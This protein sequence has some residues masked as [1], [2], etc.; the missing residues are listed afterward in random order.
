MKPHEI[1]EQITAYLLGEL[2]D[3]AAEAVRQQLGTD[4]RCRAFAQDLEA[5][6]S[7]VR[8]ALAAES[9]APTALDPERKAALVAA[10][11]Q[12]GPES[13]PA[14][15]KTLIVFPR[16]A[17]WFAQAAAVAA[18]VVVL[19][20]VLSVRFTGRSSESA[21][22]LRKS[23]EDMVVASAEQ[24]A[25]MESFDD[26]AQP[27]D[28]ADMV[29]SFA[30]GS[31]DRSESESLIHAS[32]FRTRQ[33]TA[34]QKEMLADA[35][36]V[37]GGAGRQ[38]DEPIDVAAPLPR[39][40]PVTEPTITTRLAEPMAT[41]GE[42]AQ[43]GA[44]EAAMASTIGDV[45]VLAAR[46]GDREDA[47]GSVLFADTDGD[48]LDVSMGQAASEFRP[49]S[50]R[51]ARREG[52]A[53]VTSENAVGYVLRSPQPTKGA[54][55]RAPEGD[56]SDDAPEGLLGREIVGWHEAPPEE[57]ELAKSF[58]AF[59]APDSVPASKPGVAGDA[60]GENEDLTAGDEGVVVLNGGAAFTVKKDSLTDIAE[61]DGISPE[62]VDVNGKVAGDLERRMESVSEAIHEESREV[63]FAWALIDDDGLGDGAEDLPALDAETPDEPR[64]QPNARIATKPKGPA[65][66]AGSVAGDE[67]GTVVVLGD[68]PLV[69]KL[70]AKGEVANEESGE[71]AAGAST[72]VLGAKVKGTTVAAEP[73]IGKYVFAPSPDSAKEGARTSV[74]AGGVERY[75][76]RY[77]GTLGRVDERQLAEAGGISMFASRPSHP[78][79]DTAVEPVSTFG[80]DVD[81][82]SYTLA[83]LHILRGF[84][85][86]PEAIRV[87]EVVNAF[88]YDYE[89]PVKQTFAVRATYAPA[90]FG[91][92]D[93]LRIAVKGKRIGR[94]QQQRAVLT[95]LVD[96][97]GSMDT[98]GRLGLV[99][100]SLR[101]LVETLHEEDRVAI[102]QVDT[103]A[104]MVLDYT[105]VSEREKVLE[106]VSQLNCSGSTHLSGGIRLAYELA[107]GARRA[108]AVNRVIILS[109]G[110]A[111]L[112]SDD[113]EAI[114]RQVEA[115]RD[116][117]ITC[118]VFGF[119]LGTYNDV[120]LES[121]ADKGDGAYRFID[122]AEE[123]RRVFVEDLAA[124]LHTIAS[125]VKI[126]VE[127]DPARVRQYRQLGYE[128]RALT[129]E[130]FRDD[131]VD[132]GEVGSGQ[133]VTALYELLPG[134]DASRPIGE[135][136]IRYRDVARGEMEEI[137]HV[138]TVAEG[139]ASIEEADP[140][141]RLAAAAAEF[142]ELLRG[143]PFAAEG[144]YRAVTRLVRG[145]KAELPD[146][147]QVSELLEL[148]RRAP[149][150]ARV[151]AP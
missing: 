146:D 1:E 80:I 28:E 32:P 31:W 140:M 143:S 15:E 41:V 113:P 17:R 84:L 87:E 9:E 122:S 138:I 88:Q 39:P 118:S 125:D 43:P 119:G 73:V 107:A 144:D 42:Q 137:T 29:E 89:P 6:L 83:R 25:A 18:I 70:F 7:L 129:R 58:G 36:L 19:V 150:L 65:P 109:D 105:A 30:V 127:F 111:N 85:P 33:L 45:D 141:F 59:D 22:A 57:S 49:R 104:R 62:P 69:G 110:A 27:A 78:Y 139:V 115:Q 95:F 108:H 96:T 145:V 112:G 55:G 47:D 102:V 121:L 20:S 116:M 53:N 81:T 149:G 72:V 12:A 131:T 114:L 148:A 90:P 66:T 64:R 128:N 133:S 13:E 126:Q 75:A 2:D 52:P 120:M 101:M 50:G 82:A 98:P 79:V 35:E 40:A 60:R 76:H 54:Y 92:G 10:A 86:P 97:S 14:P 103:Q 8:D 136:R 38:F 5:T 51:P 26:Q 99:K 21:I 130:Q 56:E 44:G 142:G 77:G 3:V 61:V 124:T 100:E 24:R 46:E 67:S 123:A 11:A 106:A 63:G 37:G 151:Q 23:R 48:R 74:V 16:Y 4:E 117:G 68:V 93:L 132:A 34:E 91:E 147:P 135:V 71:R 134:A 94:D